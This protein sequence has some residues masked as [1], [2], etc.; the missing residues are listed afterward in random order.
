MVQMVRSIFVL[1]SLS[2]H[3]F[4]HPLVHTVLSLNELLGVA[5]AV[6][7]HTYRFSYSGRYCACKSAGSE[8]DTSQCTT[9][10]GPSIFLKKRG[11][12]LIALAI[13]YWIF[14]A[15]NVLFHTVFCKK[16]VHVVT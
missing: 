7:L 9:G 3:I 16:K 2:D 13:V 1:I 4:V 12:M 11:E 10:S 14:A 6:V 8:F 5:A 15:F